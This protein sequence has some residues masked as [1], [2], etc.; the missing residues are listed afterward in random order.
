VTQNSNGER[1]FGANKLEM[2]SA[3][4]YKRVKSYVFFNLCL[5]AGSDGDDETEGGK[6]FQTRAAAI[7]N[8]RSPIVEC[9]D[10]D[11][12]TRGAVF[13]DRSCRRE[14]RHQQRD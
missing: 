13:A 8:A 2:F 11:E 5:N 4:G 6:L 1:T 12:M 7:G 3:T 10:R 9:L 14:Y